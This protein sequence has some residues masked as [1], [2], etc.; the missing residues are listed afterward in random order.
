MLKDISP[1]FKHIEKQ[2]KKL[3]NTPKSIAVDTE[4]GL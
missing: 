1:H 3:K 2:I 4:E